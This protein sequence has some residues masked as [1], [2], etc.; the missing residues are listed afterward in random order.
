MQFK[1]GNQGEKNDR[2]QRHQLLLTL[3]LDHVCF[4]IA[5]KLKILSWQVLVS[6]WCLISLNHSI[7][8]NRMQSISL[9]DELQQYTRGNF[10]H[11]WYMYWCHW[12]CMSQINIYLNNYFYQVENCFKNLKLLGTCECPTW[13]EISCPG[14]RPYAFVFTQYL[15]LYKASWL[16]FII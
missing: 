6:D 12:F 9:L 4:P 15:E 1:S 13:V 11:V 3:K 7:S 14:Q 8:L 10:C 16:Y 5:P 2:F